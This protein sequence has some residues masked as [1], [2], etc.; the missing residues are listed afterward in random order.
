MYRDRYFEMK[1]EGKKGSSW[2]TLWSAKSSKFTWNFGADRSFSK[3]VSASP[4]GN[5]T[6][7]RCMFRYST[8]IDSGGAKWARFSLTLRVS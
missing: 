7:V 8:N 1:I 2:Y 3:S 5:Y 6:A 4:R